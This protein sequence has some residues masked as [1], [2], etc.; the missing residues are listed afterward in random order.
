MEKFWI[1]G[2]V[3][4]IKHVCGLF[5]IVMWLYY[6]FAVDPRDECSHIPQ[7]C[8]I[9]PVQVQYSHRIWTKYV[10][11]SNLHKTIQGPCVWFLECMAQEETA[12]VC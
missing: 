8:T 6:K 10:A 3:C 7:G 2:T 11:Q 9:V 4:P 1:R 12:P 5:S